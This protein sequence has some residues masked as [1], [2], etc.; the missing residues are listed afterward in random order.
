MVDPI[1]SPAGEAKSATESHARALVVG[2]GTNQGDRLGF[3]TRAAQALAAL[4]TLEAVASLWESEAVGPPQPRYWNSAVRLHAVGS[5]VELVD[6]LL[7]IEADLGRV[8]TVRWGPRV[9]D[10]DLLWI[11]GELSHDPR[12]EVP[13]PRL[14]E[15]SF[16]LTP[17]LELVPGAVDPRT[18]RAFDLDAAR[19]PA[20]ERIGAGHVD[21]PRWTLTR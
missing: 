19:E 14:H 16:A 11:D 10:L 1:S 5:A 20:L 2:M 21:P 8:R 13:H 12:A 17:L 7:A 15:R 3:L 6:R 4:G 18:G 9:I